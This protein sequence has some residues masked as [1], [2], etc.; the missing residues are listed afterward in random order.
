MDTM[1]ACGHRREGGAASRNDIWLFAADGSDATPSGGRNISAAH[2]LMPGSAMSRDL[3]RREGPP[4][5]PSQGGSCLAFTAPIDGSYELWRI[6]VS[7]G[8]LERLTNGRPYISGWDGG[9]H[10]SG[11]ARGPQV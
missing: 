4:V 8:R 3:T 7:D 5:I 9:P 2:D 6:A 10:R 11:S 1:A